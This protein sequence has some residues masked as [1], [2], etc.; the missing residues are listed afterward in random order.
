VVRPGIWNLRSLGLGSK[1]PVS[2]SSV[3]EKPGESPVCRDSRNKALSYD[4]KWLLFTYVF[5]HAREPRASYMLGNL[6]PQHSWETGFWKERGLFCPLQFFQGEKTMTRWCRRKTNNFPFPFWVLVWES[7][8]KR[9]V[10]KRKTNK[11]N[12]YT[13]WNHGR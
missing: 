6:H 4:R 1:T 10:N 2:A 8:I 11:F 5:C 13:S 9:Q 12:M 7:L 3:L